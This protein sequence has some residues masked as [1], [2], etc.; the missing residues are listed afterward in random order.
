[1]PTVQISEFKAKCL[2]LVDEV[3]STGEVLVVTKN[4][5]PV[6]EVRPFS[7]GRAGSPFGLHPAVEICG[8]IIAPLDE[9]A[10]DALA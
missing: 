9:D 10:W 4:G 7:G 2:A 8:D 5:K 3:A 6:A 1:M